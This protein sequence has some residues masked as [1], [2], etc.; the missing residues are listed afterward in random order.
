MVAERVLNEKIP[1]RHFRKILIFNITR[2]NLS[3]YMHRE[4][5]EIVRTGKFFKY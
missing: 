4:V 5:I 2:K 3:I 1:I